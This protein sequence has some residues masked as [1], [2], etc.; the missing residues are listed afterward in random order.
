LADEYGLDTISLGNTIGFA[1]EA[2][3]KGILKEKLDWGDYQATRDLIQEIAFRKGPLGSMLAEGTHQV[4]KKLGKGTMDFAM[5]IKGLEV[6]GYDCHA[7]PGMALAFGVC[8]IGAHHKESWIITY[9]VDVGRETYDESKVDKIIELQRIR[10]GMFEQL[11]SCRFPWIE[12]G[13]DLEWYPKYFTAATGLKWKL[14]DFWSL[15]DRVYSL[16]RAYAVR[17]YNGEWDRTMDHP[18][19]RWFEHPLSCGPLT[20]ATLD[21]D[22]YEKMLSWYYQKRGWDD[23]GIPKKKRLAEQG[24]DWVIPELEKVTTLE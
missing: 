21:Q 13:F 18:P 5:Q 8:S 16:V 17:E 3:E 7:A 11:V 20:G 23:R 9:E 15:A 6:S 14:D 22:G 4:A 10:G 19:A 12:V 1:M 2:S 24:L